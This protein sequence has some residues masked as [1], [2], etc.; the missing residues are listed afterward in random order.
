MQRSESNQEPLE[1]SSSRKLL[2]PSLEAILGFST[3]RLLRLRN[4]YRKIENPTPLEQEK[5]AAIRKELR[6]R[7]KRRWDRIN[8]LTNTESNQTEEVLNEAKTTLEGNSDDTID[9]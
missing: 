8:N 6:I 9:S 7:S 5:L 2:A 1:Q 4:S 3:K